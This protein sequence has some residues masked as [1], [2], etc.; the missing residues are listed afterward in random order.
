VSAISNDNRVDG[1]RWEL[2]LPHRERLLSLTR[3]RLPSLQ[4]AEDCVQETLLRAACFADLDEPRVGAF[5][6][7]TALRLCVDHYR[8][9]DAVRRL[10]RR[11]AAVE[12]SPGPEDM[13]CDQD[14]GS[15]LLAYATQ[16]HGREQQVMLA[17]AQGL[18]VA[19]A[20]VRLGITVKAAE[21]AFTR[22]RKRLLALYDCAMTD[23]GVAGCEPKACA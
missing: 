13:V 2:L 11:I 6:S 17:R 10:G 8:R 15:W 9:A 4:D 14:L 19:E 5:L 18:S 21:S 16:L 3:R 22:A 20:A 12:K 1:R 23:T 7:A